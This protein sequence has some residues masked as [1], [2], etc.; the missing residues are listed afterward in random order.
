MN[1]PFVKS[2]QFLLMKNAHYG[3]LVVTFISYVVLYGLIALLS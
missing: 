2:K 3:F 1:I